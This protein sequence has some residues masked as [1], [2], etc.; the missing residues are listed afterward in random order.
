MSVYATAGGITHIPTNQSAMAKDMT[1][2]LVTV[3]RR[4]VV[5]TAKITSVLPKITM[6]MTMLNRMASAIC[7][8]WLPVTGVTEKLTEDT[9][10]L[11]IGIVVLDIP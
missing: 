11:L 4:L 9:E 2:Q 3:R 6:T 5:I 1:K 7:W 10:V 8:T